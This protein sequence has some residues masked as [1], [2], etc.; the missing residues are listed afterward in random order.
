NSCVACRID[1]R[2]AP[3]SA[4]LESGQTVEIITSQGALPNPD[5]LSFVVTGKARSG[6][7]HALKYQQS[8]E[9]IVLGRRLLERALEPHQL[10]IE[11]INKRKLKTILKERGLTELDDL[12]QE[13]GLGNQM[14][15]IITRRLL[16]E[17][18]NDLSPGASGPL[19]ILGT[20]GF[21]VTYSRCCRP[22]P[23][24]TIAGHVSAGRGLVIHQEACGN[25]QELREKKEELISV[26]WS[27]KVEQEF[28]VDLRIE[29]A[30]QRGII[31]V[32][33]NAVTSADANV[34]QINMTEQD[35]HLGIVHLRLSAHDRIHL[36][37]VIKRLR[38]IKGISKIVRARN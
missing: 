33:A 31:A 12:L 29:L 37:R 21:V 7:R 32:I 5:W 6:I 8:K 20:E 16:S 1:R 15:G 14:V 3:L 22:I 23:G 2:L 25:L 27:A 4:T 26:R 13:I 30:H 24:D 34:E 38:T 35:A 9:S 11:D 18:E 19:A 28:P 36:A 10:S 17:K